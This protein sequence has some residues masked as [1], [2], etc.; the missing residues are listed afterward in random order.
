M[1][2]P[3]DSYLMAFV[4]TYGLENPFDPERVLKICRIL[5]PMLA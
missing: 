4:E 3:E 1:L 5:D 2:T